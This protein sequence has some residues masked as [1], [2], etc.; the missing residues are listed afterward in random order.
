MYYSLLNYT[1]SLK[2]FKLEQLSKDY[3]ITS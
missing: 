3:K 2:I 1:H